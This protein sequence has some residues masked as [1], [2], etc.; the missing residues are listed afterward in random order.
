MCGII[1][2]YA[3]RNVTPILLEGLHRMEYRGYDSAGISVLDKDYQI[4]R[5]R[6]LGKVAVLGEKLEKSPM[7]SGIG[8]AHT[9]W[10]THGQPSEANA[11]PHNSSDQFSVVH[12]GIIENHESLRIDL[13]SAGYEFGSE[14]DT[15]VIVHLLHS[16]VKKAG[17]YI[18]GVK[19]TVAQLDGAYA[20]AILNTEMPDRL[21]A[22]RKG[23]PL[24]VGLGVG[25]FFLASDA[26]A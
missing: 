14:T 7:D 26:A 9:R 22:V 23:S 10:A 5:T 16:E 20:I 18:E 4:Q 21:I 12:N 1:A 24:L 25:E 8:I 11:H 2:A 15:E 3:Q 6:A 13:K 19:N 17:D